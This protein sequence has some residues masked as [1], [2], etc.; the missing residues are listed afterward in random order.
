MK[1]VTLLESKILSDVYYLLK[2]DR[3]LYTRRDGTK[4]ELQRILFDRGNGAAVLLV[5][6][7]TERIIL[8]KQLRYPVITETH[9][10][11]M[12]E[13][14]AGLLDEDNPEECVKREAIEETGYEISNVKKL[15]EIHPSP[16]AVTEILYLF[17]AE[18]SSESKVE[19]GGGLPE[20][21]EDIDVLEYSFKEAF[22]MISTGE[23]TDAK[24][25]I[26][27]QHLQLNRV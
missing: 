20:E 3:F 5:N 8:T 25:I 19:A 11:M 22:E 10:G 17:I 26:L 2:Q 7:K 23:I 9:N 21:G 16:G 24:T 18:Y 4:Q 15:M 1:N 27:L 12:I 14:C 13:V 6:Y